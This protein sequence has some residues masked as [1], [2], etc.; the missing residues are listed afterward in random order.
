[1]KRSVMSY[2]PAQKRSS[3]FV[4]LALLFLI[5]LIVI[6]VLWWRGRGGSTDNGDGTV[7][8]QDTIATLKVPGD[9]DTIDKA[10]AAAQPDDIVEIGEGE[11]DLSKNTTSGVVIDKPLTLRG[12][13]M[14]K[15]IL[16]GGSKSLIGIRVPET[17]GA[18]RIENLAVRE[19]KNAGIDAVN[20]DTRIAS[21]RVVKN[22]NIGIA[23]RRTNEH[24]QITNSIIA[25]NKFNGILSEKSPVQIV[26]C[27]IVGNGPVGVTILV[28][29]EGGDTIKMSSPRIENSI[30]ADHTRVGVFFDAPAYPDQ[31]SITYTDFFNNKENIQ[32]ETDAATGK[33]KKITAQPGTGVLTVDPKFSEKDLFVLDEASPL[34]GKSSTEGDLGA[35]GEPLPELL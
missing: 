27:T 6:G 19:F 16:K 3:R 30:I 2:Q 1:M 22:D 12:A 24:T 25:Y 11:Y 35:Y 10:I 33:T 29:D 14:D 17:D 26:N 20:N 15:T 21:V 7:T 28:A 5:V 31:S 18:V 32:Q 4:W 9:Y 23:L 13:G 8:P 34:K